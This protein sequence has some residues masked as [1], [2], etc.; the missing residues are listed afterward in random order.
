LKKPAVVAYVMGMAGRRFTRRVEDFTC[1]S[2]G[3]EVAGDGYTNHCPSCLWSRHVD[4]NPGDRMAGCGGM[5]E[6]AAVLVEGDGYVIVHRCRACGH[7]GRNR[8]APEDD[9]AALLRHAGPHAARGRA[10]RPPLR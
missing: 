4:V 8:S 3:R 2:C 7:V 1:G 5:M 6:P 9:F 10:R